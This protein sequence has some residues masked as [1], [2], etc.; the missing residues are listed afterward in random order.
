MG[1]TPKK[2]DTDHPQVTVELNPI[3]DVMVKGIL[4]IRNRQFVEITRVAN[5]LRTKLSSDT[6]YESTRVW[7]WEGKPLSQRLAID[8][9]AQAPE[10]LSSLQP[11]YNK[12]L[13]EKAL[14]FMGRK[15]TPSLDR[16]GLG[17][18]VSLSEA[19][20][21]CFV[22]YDIAYKMISTESTFEHTHIFKS[23]KHME[24]TATLKFLPKDDGNDA[25]SIHFHTNNID[26]YGTIQFNVNIN[27]HNETIHS[28]AANI[29]Y[30]YSTELLKNINEQC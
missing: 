6:S 21:M 24:E 2:D 29:M 3:V 8:M 18:I 23:S 17:K 27:G 16:G 25:V 15:T 14:V 9:V 30:K 12:S 13:F 26:A 20:E 10:I 5:Q 4:S 19:S 1:R 7:K 11:I 28:R 22:M